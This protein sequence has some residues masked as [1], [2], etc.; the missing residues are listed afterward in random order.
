MLV[1]HL[2]TPLRFERMRLCGL[3]GANDEFLMATI[4]QT[5]DAWCGRQRPRRRHQHD[6]GHPQLLANWPKMYVQNGSR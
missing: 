2:K 3:N 6:G 1:A 4:T 5:Y